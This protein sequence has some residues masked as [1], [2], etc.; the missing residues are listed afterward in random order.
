[1]QIAIRAK[2]LFIKLMAG[3]NFTARLKFSHTQR[4]LDIQ[5]ET[6][7][8]A[9]AINDTRKRAANNLSGGA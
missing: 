1:M 9:Q 5:V 8:A 7:E 4:T 6:Q 2:M 3:R